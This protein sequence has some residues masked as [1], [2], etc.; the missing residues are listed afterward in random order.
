MGTRLVRQRLE[1]REH[2]SV[3]QYVFSSCLPL[4]TRQG[5][6]ENITTT[7]VQRMKTGPYFALALIVVTGEAFA[8]SPLS[9]TQDCFIASGGT[10]AGYNLRCKGL[11]ISEGEAAERYLNLFT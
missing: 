11:P 4:S 2:S 10:A 8:G 5:D 7:A 6:N 1:P 3:R 9:M